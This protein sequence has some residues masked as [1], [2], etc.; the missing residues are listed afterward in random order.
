[1]VGLQA[2][3][4]LWRGEAEGAVGDATLAQP[5]PDPVKQTQR[6]AERGGHPAAAAI[7]PAIAP[8][9]R[10]RRLRPAAAAARVDDR[11]GLGVREGGARSDDRLSD[12]RGA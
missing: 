3:G 1:V 12:P 10:R 11:L 7:A 5:P 2:G 6:A 8:A 4:H 9:L